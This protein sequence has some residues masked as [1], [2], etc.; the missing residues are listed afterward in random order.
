MLFIRVFVREVGAQYHS[1]DSANDT[2]L[3]KE[4]SAGFAVSSTFAANATES[5]DPMAKK[6]LNKAGEIKKRSKSCL[7]TQE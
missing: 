1:Q 4:P 3:L 6:L 2:V 5:Y 7:K